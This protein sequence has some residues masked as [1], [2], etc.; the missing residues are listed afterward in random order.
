MQITLI[1]YHPVNLQKCFTTG[2]L[3]P[4]IL[5]SLSVERFVSIWC[6]VVIQITLQ[7]CVSVS[8]FSESRFGECNLLRKINSL[9]S[10]VQFDVANFLDNFL[11]SVNLVSRNPFSIGV[12]S[13]SRCRR[14]NMQNKIL[15]NFNIFSWS[16]SSLSPLPD[17]SVNKMS[18]RKKMLVKAKFSVDFWST[19]S[20]N[21][22]LV[23]CTQAP[24]F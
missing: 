11:S 22:K 1:K 12:S 19:N 2:G 21:A 14:V 17:Y 16:L 13:R 10:E 9:T 18:K 24:N 6:R 7:F 8:Q 5:Y 23:P 4:L 15:Y 20:L 3:W